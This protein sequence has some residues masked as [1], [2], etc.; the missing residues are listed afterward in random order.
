MSRIPRAQPMP[1]VVDGI[2][3]THWPTGA[4]DDVDT[5]VEL[6]C[7]AVATYAHQAPFLRFD[8][9]DLDRARRL[10][11]AIIGDRSIDLDAVCVSYLRQY[12]R[13]RGDR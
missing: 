11:R 1:V 2:T 4:T 7:E 6:L 13:P 10:A 8:E 3:V 12:G 5:T 9:G